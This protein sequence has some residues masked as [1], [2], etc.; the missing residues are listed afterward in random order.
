MDRKSIAI[1][2]VCFILLML[3]FPLVNRIFPP[4]PLAPG[5]TNA[6]SVTVTG[7]NQAAPVEQPSASTDTAFAPAVPAIPTL[8]ANTNAPEQTVV[9]TNNHGRF[10]FTS[11]GGGVKLIEL[12]EYPETVMTRR[13]AKAGEDPGMATLNTHTPAPTLA[14]LDGPAVQGDGVY[15]L[16]S[17]ENTLRAE[18]TLANGLS[19]VKTFTLSTNYLVSSTVRLENRSGQPLQLPAQEWVVGTATP[20]N[21]QDDGSAVGAM[22]FNGS[23]D[24]DV[25]APWFANKTLGCFPGTPRSEFRDGQS[26]VVWVAVHNQFF[27]LAAMPEHPAQQVVVRKISLPRFTGEQ[28][29]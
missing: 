15:E 10:T 18:K 16:T 21:P 17:T 19:I 27:T 22:W 5:A 12:P 2:V 23:K 13:E 3:W 1:L 20:L 9:L 29:R 11:H 7:T 4:K 26:N 6:T 25:S 14:L 8:V 28:A 24:Q